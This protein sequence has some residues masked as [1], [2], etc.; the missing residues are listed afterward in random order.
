MSGAITS[1][2]QRTA[3]CGAARE[4]VERDLAGDREVVVAGEAQ[5][6]VLARE[7]DARVGV[8]AVADEVAEAPDL[9]DRVVGDV[10]EH[11]LERLAIAVDVRDDCDLHVRRLTR[12]QAGSTAVLQQSSAAV[13]GRAGRRCAILRDS[14][15]APH[16][17][18]ACRA[19][20]GAARDR[21]WV[22]ALA[23]AVA[24]RRGGGASRC[25][26][27]TA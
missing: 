25:G 17:Q 10:A 9:L 8:G 15:G 2:V 22:G 14:A 5:V 18:Y 16:R 20:A 12:P 27:A 24:L 19:V 21:G 26:R 4:V 7:V 1:W 6:G 3:I 13:A 23:A 11:R